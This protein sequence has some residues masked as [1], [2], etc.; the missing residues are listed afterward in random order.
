MKIPRKREETGL[1]KVDGCGFGPLRQ[2]ALR[3]RRPRLRH[4][5]GLPIGGA[6]EQHDLPAGAGD[7]VLPL[8]LAFDFDHIEAFIPKLSEVFMG[9]HG[10]NGRSSTCFHPKSAL[11]HVI[12][13]WR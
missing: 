7:V 12:S 8:P 9:F 6:D 13:R 4:G 3:A 5:R 2:R 11:K 1:R 10:R